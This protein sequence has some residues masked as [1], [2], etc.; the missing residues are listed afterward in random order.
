MAKTHSVDISVKFDAQELKNAV[1]QTQREAQN[2]FDLKDANIEVELS[3]TNV[4]ITA[5]SDI[6]INS[7]YDILLKKVIGR[8]LSGKVVKRTEIKEIGGMRVREEMELVKALDQE[9]AKKIS[10]NIREN[11][12]KAKPSIQGDT[13]RVVSPKIDELQAIMA[14]LKSDEKLEVPLEFGNFK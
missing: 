3:E 4:K 5:N 10:K 2:R 13:I 1:D 11:F 6:Q 14:M 12:P 9:N 8:G 7:V